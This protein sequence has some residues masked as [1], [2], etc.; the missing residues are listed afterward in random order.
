MNADVPLPNGLGAVWLTLLT[1]SQ[2][3][4]E[5]GKLDI[6]GDLRRLRLSSPDPQALKGFLQ[7]NSK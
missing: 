2:M 1:I 4:R 5:D 6:E 7:A 3:F